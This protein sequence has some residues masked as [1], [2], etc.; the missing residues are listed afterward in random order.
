MDLPKAYSAKDYEA[1]IYQRWE[2]A[3]AFQPVKSKGDPFVVTLPPPNATG[4]LH[5]G[6][7]MMIALEDI[8][9][10]YWRM[11]GRETLWVPGTDHA[12]IATE[13]TV[14]KKLI[15]ERGI[16]DPREEL[17][18]EKLLD[19]IH[20]FVEDS[21][22][23]IRGQVRAM[24]ASVDWTRERYT[25]EP[26]INRVVNEVFIKMYNDGL[27]YRGHRIV[28]W[29]PKLQ[30][31]VSDDEVERVEETAAF[32]TFKYG[33]FEI[34]TAR[35]ETKFGDKYVVVHPDDARYK[36]WKDGDTFEVDW[37]N[38]TITATLIKDE[39]VDPEF[40]TGAMTITP[41][42]DVTDFE[43]A[44]RH[45]LDK[46]QI[47]D[48]D[49]LLLPIAGD[50]KGMPI[51]EARS[52]VVEILDKKGL[53]VS[54]D[55]NYSHNVA[56][57]SRGRGIIEPQIMLQWFIDVDKPVVAW[58]GTDMSL[59][60]VLRSV[61]EDS[62]IEIIPKRFEKIY[63]HWIDNLHDWCISRQIWWGH[64]I[65]VWYKGE[66]M[67]VGIEA[68]DQ[69]SGWE[70][71]P[72]TLDTWFSSALWTWSTLIDQDQALDMKNSLSDILKHSPDF[73]R[74]H[75]TSVLETGYDILFFW[76]ARMILSTTYVIGDVPFKQVYLHGM[77]RTREGS[78]MSKSKPETTIDPLEIIP[79]FGA[80]SLRLAMTLGMSPGS[81]TR[82]YKEKIAGYRNFCNKLWNV[83]RYALSQ[84]Q[85]DYTP[86][87]P[88]F[89]TAS[90]QWILSR[91][92]DTITT[93]SEQIE[94]YRFSDAGQA[95]YHFLWNDFA[96][97]YLE[98]HKVQSNIDVLLYVLE[99]TLKLAHPFAPFVTEA[100]WQ[101]LPHKEK[102]LITSEWPTVIDQDGD[103][104]EFEQIRTIV[105]EVRNLKTE[106][107]I[108]DTT[109]YHKESAFLDTNQ[110]LITHM[111][112]LKGVRQVTDGKG[113]HLTETDISAWLDVEENAT[114]DYLMK[115]IGQRSK[116]KKQAESLQA[117]LDNHEYTKKAP[118]ELVDESKANLDELNRRIE[119]LSGRI[120]TTEQSIQ[121]F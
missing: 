1:D 5:L 75:P 25:M 48:K 45:Q 6:H 121:E 56:V 109:L 95:V 27:I 108:A 59:K 17:G 58:K 62:E 110:E 37:I 111:T 74:Y 79:E 78:K 90:E 51:E 12:A 72:D 61:V 11:K 53:L 22:D 8:M 68:P 114:R 30:T 106:L 34:G 103:V 28:N 66:E 115:L 71:D 89:E 50:L 92:N 49:G 86:S 113:L 57:N 40:G 36:K 9:V 119:R 41:W 99:T 42:H 10:R 87:K 96:D 67:H 23:T 13:N 118:K 15:D 81:D 97:W 55:E 26:G 88:R 116:L 77:V 104:D 112:G 91:L 82:L 4:T 64:R 105:N 107:D 94:A 35:P 47:I 3:G 46:E 20:S 93:V 14:I 39:A 2:D 76:V 70:Q 63:Y 60:Q 83:S 65:P 44:E 18:R 19:E 16:A 98:I 52:K 31:T 33:P 24:G 32:Y 21:R 117:R 7:S 38:G 54:T 80:D 84:V 69:N 29:D 120:E 100:V 102:L 101:Y 43:I 85:P 73:Q